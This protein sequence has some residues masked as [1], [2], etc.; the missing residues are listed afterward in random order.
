MALIAARILRPCSK[1]ATSRG[2]EADTLSDSLGEE[3]GVADADEDELYAAMDWLVERQQAIEQRLAKKHLAEGSV[4]LYDLT[5]SYFEGRSCPLAKHGYSRDGKR[6]K[7]QIVFGLL[8][9]RQGCP[10]AVEVFE[11]NSAD[12]STVSRQVEKLR[13]R[14]ALSRVVMVGD[15]GMLTSARIRQDLEPAGLDWVSALRSTDIHDLVQRQVLQP[16]LFD[17]RGPRRDPLR[18]E[19]P[20]R[21]SG[22]V[23]QSTAGPRAHPQAPGLVAGHRS[24]PRKGA[25]RHLEG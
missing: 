16:S 10:V 2:L 13:Q 25:R 3:L 6:G 14:F 12:P 5:S 1:L 7:L 17:Q 8:C 20:G 22:G 24:R 4:V 15:R 21:T 19:V 18:G 23:P 9:D 11:G